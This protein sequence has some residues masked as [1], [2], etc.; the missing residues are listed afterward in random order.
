VQLREQTNT[1]LLHS[2]HGRL[3]CSSCGKLLLVPL[4]PGLLELLLKPV[5]PRTSF[6]YRILQRR[7]AALYM[8][9]GSVLYVFVRVCVYE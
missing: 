9:L 7:H 2:T 4:L 1:H 3:V 6:V 5:S 8:L